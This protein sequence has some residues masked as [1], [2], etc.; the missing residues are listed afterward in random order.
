MMLSLEEALDRILLKIKPL[1]SETIRVSEAEGR[2]VSKPLTAGISLPLW[3]NSAMDGYAV[4]AAD[5]A[6][7]SEGNPV[8]LKCL[9]ET[10]AGSIFE[11]IV[12]PGTCLRLFTGSPCLKGRM[13]S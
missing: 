6:S 12:G 4:Q 2:V 5:L 3:D 8:A 7:A 1:E 13:L 10:P 11:G 9:G